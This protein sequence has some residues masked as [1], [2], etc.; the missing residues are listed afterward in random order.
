[1]LVANSD[2]VP[3]HRLA[4]EVAVTIGDEEFSINCFSISLGEFDLILGFDFLRTLGP[5]LWDCEN[6]SMAFTRAGRRILWTGLGSSS[7]DTTR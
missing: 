5:V 2:R 6:L 4:H 1:M 3:C 7:D